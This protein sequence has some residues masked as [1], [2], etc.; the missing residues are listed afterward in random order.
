MSD[1]A[2]FYSAL[3]DKLTAVRRQ[4]EDLADFLTQVPGG[5]ASAEHV[6]GAL[7]VRLKANL[8]A[9]QCYPEDIENNDLTRPLRQAFDRV[10]C[11]LRNLLEAQENSLLGCGRKGAFGIAGMLSVPSETLFDM[12][13]HL[14]IP[15]AGAIRG[16]WIGVACKQLPADHPLLAAVAPED[17]Y[18]TMYKGPCLLFGRPRSTSGTRFGTALDSPPAWVTLSQVA[19]WTRHARQM[20][21][22]EAEAERQHRVYEAQLHNLCNRR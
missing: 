16:K 9:H 19:Q 4:M 11:N 8:P 10:D 22:A 12:E 14:R 1:V 7:Q 17:R 13:I 3:D 6:E 15:E 20:Q 2:T 18:L 21:L 5:A